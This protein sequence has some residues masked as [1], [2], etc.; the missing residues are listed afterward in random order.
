MGQSVTCAPFMCSGNDCVSTCQTAEDCVA[1]ATCTN[2]SCGKRGLGQSCRAASEC[3]SDH[4]VDGVCCNEACAGK[5][6]FCALSESTG[7]CSNVPADFADPRA[8]RGET[9]ATKI[10]EDR[11]AA[12]C[13]TNG[14]CD[15]AGSC[16]LYPR[17]AACSSESCDG[18]SDEYLGPST[19]NGAGMCIAPAARACAPFQCNGQR[20]GATCGSDADCVAPNTCQNGSCGKK[21]DGQLCTRA[22]DCDSGFCAQG[23]CCATAC[24]TSCHS[25]ALAGKEGSCEV[26]PNGGR[27][28]R[29]ACQDQS[30]ATCGN[31]GACDGQGACRKYASGTVCSGATCAA[32]QGQGA[33]QCNGAGTCVAGGITPCSPY[34]CNV[35]GSA[36]FDACSD[37]AQCAPGNLCVGGRCGKKGNGAACSGADECTSGFCTDGVCCENACAGLC[38]TCALAARPGQCVNV[39]AGQSDTGNACAAT[40]RATCGAD[41]TCDG[42]GACRLW[43]VG[44]SCAAPVCSADGTTL[45]NRAC[46][47]SGICQDNPKKCGDYVCSGT[48]CKTTCRTDADCSG[49]KKCRGGSGKCI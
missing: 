21:G 13:G 34:V 44:T 28:P 1:P 7:R 12:T 2:G 18:A 11:G 19:C 42:E 39:P 24:D 31:D 40:A 47:G 36:C 29:A 4:C 33:S 22:E 45:L 26:V 30:A 46:N 41:G 37:N 10:C 14:R 15:G 20:C 35:A 27:D 8:A 3:L 16:A 9:D 49:P 5:C 25:C 43:P 38:K 6:R 17:G 48:A 32:G 23:V